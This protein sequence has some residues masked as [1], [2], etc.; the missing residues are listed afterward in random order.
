MN[1]ELFGEP[2]VV[3][4]SPFCSAIRDFVKKIVEATLQAKLELLKCNLCNL[5]GMTGDGRGYE[6]LGIMYTE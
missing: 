6:S 1:L 3:F 5:K 4:A 2:V